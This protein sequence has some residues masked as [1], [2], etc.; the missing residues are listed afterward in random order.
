MSVSL[1]KGG[2]VSLK[3]TVPGLR[4]VRIG[5][6]WDVPAGGTMA[7]DLYACAFLLG[8]GGKVRRDEDFV[9]YNNLQSA[10]GAVRHGGDNRTGKGAGDDET[11]LVD[12]EQLPAD[13]S[14]VVV[15]VTIHEA[16]ARQQSFARVENAYVRLV[17]QVG[18]QEVARYDLGR[19]GTGETGML[20]GELVRESDDWSFLAV[21]DGMFGGL[22]TVAELHGV[23]VS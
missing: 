12:L 20:F 1:K 3:K 2:K 23:D 4:R 16:E 5:L 18:E 6:G 21:G 7:F 17:N 8:R 10:C 13:V 14:R 22:L 11:I 15:A 9:F 19:I